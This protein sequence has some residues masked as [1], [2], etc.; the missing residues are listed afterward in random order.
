MCTDLIHEQSYLPYYGFYLA[1]KMSHVPSIFTSVSKVF[2]IFGDG[3]LNCGTQGKIKRTKGIH[4][5]E[6]KYLASVVKPEVLLR[7]PTR[8]QNSV[9]FLGEPPRHR[10]FPTLQQDG[11]K[12]ISLRYIIT[13]GN[14]VA[15]AH[16]Q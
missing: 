9:A 11:S 7:S 4:T 3:L 5:E 15:S 6:F 13:S 8:G 12:A 2:C 10:A 14:V 1:M 16:G